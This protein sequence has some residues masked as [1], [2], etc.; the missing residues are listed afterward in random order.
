MKK[1]MSFILCFLLMGCEITTQEVNVDLFDVEEALYIAGEYMS[2]LSKGEVG[3]A[4][5]LCSDIY[6]SDE[7]AEK[8]IKNK[9]VAYKIKDVSEGANYAYVKYLVIREDNQV[10]ADLDSIEL[11]VTKENYEYKVNNV[12]AKNIK[13][14]YLD[15][16]NLRIIDSENGKSNLLLRKR[17][18]PKEVFAKGDEVTL[19]MDTV[20]EMEFKKINIGFKGDVIGIT[21]SNGSDTLVVL[22]TV[23]DTK[24]SNKSSSSNIQIFNSDVD[25]ILEKPIAEKVLGYD[26]INEEEIEKVLFTDNDE[27]L[28]LNIK[29]SGRG[30][31]VRI[32]KNPTGELLDFKLNEEFPNDRYS[33]K[34]QKITEEGISIGVIPISSE[35][36]KEGDYIVDIKN[37]NIYKDE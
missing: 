10:K 20:P 36:D 27:A 18:V 31:E 12:E 25:E 22:A 16:D 1:L 19:T 4:D 13:Q 5:A 9:F 34:V 28:V 26:L 17:D 6:I 32:Y 8:L 35:G 29:K 3:I 30:S 2:A 23:N 37:M 24:D 15:N 21:L 33:V 14:V 7:E 11:K